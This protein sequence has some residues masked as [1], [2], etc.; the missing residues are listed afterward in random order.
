MDADVRRRVVNRLRSLDDWLLSA[1]AWLDV[2][3]VLGD[4]EAAV[5]AD[6]ASAV[7]ETLTRLQALESSLRAQ[8]LPGT[9][10]TLIPPDR[11]EQRNVLVGRLTL[12]LDCS[13]EQRNASG[14]TP[15][16]G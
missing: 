16:T 15:P 14:T 7:D 12:D 1:E 2:G 10:K 13:A 6:S 4:L 11:R 9:R 3:R 8:S 5:A